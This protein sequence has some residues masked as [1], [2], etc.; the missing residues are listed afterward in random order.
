[1]VVFVAFLLFLGFGF[2]AFYL[3]V[4]GGYVPDRHR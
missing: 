1:M 3:G 2:D 4:G